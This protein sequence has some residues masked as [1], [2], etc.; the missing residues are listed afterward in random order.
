M[1]KVLKKLFAPKEVRLV[2]GLLDEASHKFGY[3]SFELVRG[4]VERY[5]LDNTAE[6]TKS[7]RNGIPP[8]TIL[9]AA[10]AN[11]SGDLIASGQYHM[12]RGVLNPMGKGG[13]LLAIFDGSIDEMNNM[14]AIDDREADEQKSGIREQIKMVG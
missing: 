3:S 11:Y 12:Y 1:K 9:Y 10:I 7:V 2:F 4:L 14:G 6:I 5:T 13:D 8:R